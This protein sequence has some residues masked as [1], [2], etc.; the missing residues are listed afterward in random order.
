MLNENNKE[1]IEKL[2]ENAKEGAKDV[3]NLEPVAA[4][5]NGD[6]GNLAYTIG[7]T[8]AAALI[9]VGLGIGGAEIY[10]RLKARKKAKNDEENNDVITEEN[11]DI[12]EE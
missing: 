6:T 3:A 1:I 12:I 11:D 4:I 8:V 7:K 2:A 5:N 10:S 9:G